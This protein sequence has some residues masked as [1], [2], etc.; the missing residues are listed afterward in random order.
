[1]VYNKKVYMYGWYNKNTKQQKTFKLP[2]DY[3][4]YVE[5][6]NYKIFA[7]KSKFYFF[8]FDIELYSHPYH[9]SIVI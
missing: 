5:I 9:F 8:W 2:L 3:V 1:M 4:L 7:K 6:W